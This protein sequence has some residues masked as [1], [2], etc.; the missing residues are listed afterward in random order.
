MVKLASTDTASLFNFTASIERVDHED[1]ATSQLAQK[2]PDVDPNKSLQ[3]NMVD[4][5]LLH[6]LRE[7]D[8]SVTIQSAAMR[9]LM[10]R[11]E[12]PDPK[13]LERLKTMEMGKLES[14]RQVM[15]IK[16]KYDVEGAEGKMNQLL[17]GM[18]KN[19]IYD[20]KRGREIGTDEIHTRLAG[21]LKLNSQVG[22]GKGK[23]GV[24][25]SRDLCG[26]YWRDI[27]KRKGGS[28]GISCTLSYIGNIAD[29]CDGK[30]WPIL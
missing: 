13:A 25:Q 29:I 16:H 24:D 27:L 2:N 4:L 26:V 3:D 20:Q 15:K 5:Y 19:R 9:K 12:G 1:L 21:V 28:G 11:P 17:A 18:V 22:K 8:P 23:D 10:S 7:M 30:V 14:M 6:F